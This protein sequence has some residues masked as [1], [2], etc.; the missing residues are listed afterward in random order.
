[1]VPHSSIPPLR[2]ANAISILLLLIAASQYALR[3][4]APLLVA[5]LAVLL[6]PLLWERISMP[7][8]V[9]LHPAAAMTGA[10]LLA[11]YFPR[12]LQDVARR[13]AEEQLRRDRLGRYFSPHVAERIEQSADA[14]HREVTVLVSDIRG[15]T[16]MSER[17][18]AAE[19]VTMLDDY[20][21]VMVDVL[22]RHE[23]TLDSFMGDGIL[24]HFG[25]PLDQPDHASRAVLCAR[26]M[27]EALE[28]LNE[29]R[30]ARGEAEL[31]IGI[32]IHTG[33]ALVG[34]IGPE[35][36]RDYTVIGDTVNVAS[37]IESLTK[38]RGVPVLVTEATRAAAVGFEWSS[39]THVSI[40][41]KAAPIA[42]FVPS[43]AEPS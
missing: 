26:D 15:F 18:S 39:A 41:G 40:R 35:R 21:E 2:I 31:R 7:P 24:A 43:F 10:A 30:R 36:R 16:T 3:P 23:G 25:A 27:L 28:G 42:T 32:G 1:V 14:E 29:K 12:R 19:V 11:L 9:W 20:R 38:E 6:Q 33:D 4:L 13:V 8:I 17:M 5:A 22:F 37:R 34:G